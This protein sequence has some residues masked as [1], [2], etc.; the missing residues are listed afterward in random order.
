MSAPPATGLRIDYDRAPKEL[1]AWVEAVL[2]AAVIK[3]T[4]QPGGFSPGVAARLECSD[5][6]RAFCKAASQRSEQ[7]ALYHR[8]EQRV[9]AAIPATAPVPR[10]LSAYDDGGWVGLLLQDIDG[11]QPRLPWQPD[12]L[13]RVVDALDELSRD[14]TPSPVSTVPTVAEAEAAEFTNWRALC[15]GPTTPALD[16]WIRRNLTQLAELEPSWV[17]A[18][19]GD[20]LLHLDLRADNMLLTAD[21]VWVVDWPAACTGKPWVDIATFASSV[22]MQGGPKPEELLAASA[23]GRTAGHDELTAWV[24][25]LAGYFVGHSLLPAPPGLP[26]VRAF[27]AAQ[28]VVAVEWLR[29]LTGWA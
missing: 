15:D 13:T 29:G 1:H 23:V 24:C 16:P 26:T 11:Q 6:S 4:T 28:G 22:R 14:L 19:E 3:A 12:E 2:G 20:T 18:S 25:A 21:R 9:T 7:A 5:G 17:T 10:L 8:R 27:Q